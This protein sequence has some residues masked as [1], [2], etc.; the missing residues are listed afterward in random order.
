VASP[1]NAAL[2]A[3]CAVAGNTWHGSARY[4][5]CVPESVTAPG[6]KEYAGLPDKNPLRCLRSS[7]L[8]ALFSC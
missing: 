4:A 3:G 7:V 5:A 6:S 8:N 1:E 2:R